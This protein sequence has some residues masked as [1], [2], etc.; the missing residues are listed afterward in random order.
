MKGTV[1]RDIKP[2]NPLKISRRSDPE[3]GDDMF[4]R[5]DVDFPR[6]TRPYIPEERILQVGA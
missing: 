6:I 3:D 5:N 4:L 2:C 1:F